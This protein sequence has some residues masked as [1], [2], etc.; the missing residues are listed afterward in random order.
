M[1]SEP[2]LLPSPQLLALLADRGV[3]QELLERV[4]RAMVEGQLGAPP[5]PNL[6]LG[7]SADE[8]VVIVNYRS[9]LQPPPSCD[10]AKAPPRW[11]SLRTAQFSHMTRNGSRRFWAEE[12]TLRTACMYTSTIRTG[13]RG[14]V[15][16]ETA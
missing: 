10:L 6:M 4:A 16:T 1:S 12:C 7:D 15:L 11:W 3:P 14:L 5:D 9:A 8:P 2:P 13:N